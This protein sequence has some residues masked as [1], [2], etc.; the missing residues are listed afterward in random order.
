MTNAYC[1]TRK[2]RYKI[3]FTCQEY[4]SET[5]YT[6]SAVRKSYETSPPHRMNNTAPI[7]H[8]ECDTRYL[9]YD[10]ATRDSNTPTTHA[11]PGTHGPRDE[12]A[13]PEQ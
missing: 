5:R 11:N 2:L 9:W 1:G 10:A 6:K 12:T 13:S 4:L 8:E 7:L 3:A